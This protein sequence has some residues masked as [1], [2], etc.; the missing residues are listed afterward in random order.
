[1]ISAN[2]PALIVVLPLLAALLCPLVGGPRRSWGLAVVVTA[3][4]FAGSLA[5]LDRVASEGVIEYSMGGWPP[6]YGITY[7]IDSLNA[8]FLVVVS[9]I[10]AVVTVPGLL[11]SSEEVGR[12]RLGFFHAVYL[13]CLTGLLGIT[14]TGDAFNVYVLLEV[15]SLATYGLVAMGKNRR[16]RLAAFKYLILGSLGATF[17]LIGL[18]YLYALTGTLDMADLATRVQGLEDN[19][20]LRSA[21][22]FLLMGI[23]LKSALFPLHSWLPDA[24]GEAPSAVAALLAGTATKVGLYM[25]ARFSLGIFGSELFYETLHGRPILTA[26]GG[27]AVIYGSVTALRQ[28]HAGRLLAYSSVAHTGYIAMAFALPSKIGIAGGLL[29]VIAHALTKGGM[30]LALG[31]VRHRIGGLDLPRMAGLGHR[32][33]G[34]AAALLLGCL[35]LVGMPLTAGFVSKWSI[36]TGALEA[37]AWPVVTIL[38]L[39]ALLAAL[40]GWKLVST[41]Y[42]K[43]APEG[44]PAGEAPWPLV[45]PTWVLIGASLLLGLFSAGTVALALRAVEA[46]S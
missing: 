36:I 18:G 34:T 11:T 20:A 30:F 24:Y 4:S 3:L 12:H 5:L 32:M 44:G 43:E 17:I 40:Y 23:A 6:P 31:A 45:V 7:R 46:L 37:G 28:N 9:G 22:A 13:L 16:S 19:L 39:G 15:S 26:C 14:I 8:L 35:G 41:L 33:P 27:I 25:L 21:F 42:L 10:A 29:H 2:L 38:V 1:M